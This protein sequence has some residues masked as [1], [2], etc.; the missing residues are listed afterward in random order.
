MVF[1]YA[2]ANWAAALVFFVVV[3]AAA[4]SLNSLLYS[5]GRHLYEIAE[6][7]PSPAIAK[8]GV[9]S[10]TKVPAR[11]IIAS[12]I[13]V[14]LSPAIEM[15]P[16]VSGAFVMFSSASSA[17]IIFIYILTMIA[18]YRYRNSPQFMANGFRMPAYRVLNPLTTAFFVF[19]YCTLF[20]GADTRGP[21]IAGL[22]WLVVF[23]GYCV[24]HERFQN[25]D[26]KQSIDSAGDAHA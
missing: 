11:A 2:G 25:R 24:L 20:I 17:V 8:L 10:K 9:V 19:I 16:R 5:A 12:A 15:I 3:T 6:D 23:G 22:V 14:L 18:H 21:A 13:L 26:L 4:S 7:S 1:E